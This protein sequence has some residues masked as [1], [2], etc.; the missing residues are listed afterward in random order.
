MACSTCAPPGLGLTLQ[1]TAA[2]GN[3]RRKEARLD[4]RLRALESSV[5]QIL[6]LQI[7]M[8]KDLSLIGGAVQKSNPLPDS[9]DSVS[10]G[11]S[12]RVDR[13]EHLLFAADF[14]HF[15]EVSRRLKEL[16]LECKDD[17][18]H[19]PELERS[20]EKGVA[21][22]PAIKMLC[23][24]HEDTFAVNV[25]GAKND[26][27]LLPQC[28]LYEIHSEGDAAE[29]SFH[30]EVDPLQENDPWS[31]SKREVVVEGSKWGPLIAKVLRHQRH[32]AA[33]TAKAEHK[34][35]L[36]IAMMGRQLQTV[37]DAGVNRCGGQQWRS[38]H[39]GGC[40]WNSVEP[41]AATCNV[42]L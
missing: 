7:E 6:A 9:T 20:P 31:L 33:F 38:I 39:G 14:G 18:T 25:E 5:Q 37:S 12:R 10:A 34:L 27:Q 41:S 11:L 30:D 36:L 32:I 13:M 28:L 16:D 22:T 17:I 24:I 23:D 29:V 26:K 19:E 2:Q 42:D 21:H 40:V 35:D 8:R 3:R 1:E 4:D 15:D